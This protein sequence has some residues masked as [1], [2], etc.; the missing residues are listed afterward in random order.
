MSRDFAHLNGVSGCSSVRSGVL[1]NTSQVSRIDIGMAHTR[2]PSCS[3]HSLPPIPDSAKKWSQDGGDHATRE[4]GALSRTGYPRYCTVSVPLA[5]HCVSSSASGKTSTARIY[6]LWLPTNLALKA[7]RQRTIRVF[8]S[9]CRVTIHRP[10]RQQGLGLRRQEHGIDDG[11]GILPSS[12]R[13]TAS[14]T[15]RGARSVHSCSGKRARDCGVGCR[16]SPWFR[17]MA[18]R[19]T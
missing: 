12:A 2:S 18:G 4:L 8:T 9:R 13:S 19:G 17:R 16:A 3:M 1:R 11:I 14:A 5:F 6:T 10:V 7:R 15:R